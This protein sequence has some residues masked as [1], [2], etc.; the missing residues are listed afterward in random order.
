MKLTDYTPEEIKSAM[1]H[2]NVTPLNVLREL[3]KR[4]GKGVSTSMISAI[5][6]QRKS[7]R[8]NRVEK[9]IVEMCAWELEKQ[10]S[11]RKFEDLGKSDPGNDYTSFICATCGEVI[12]VDQDG[13]DDNA[14]RVKMEDG[15]IKCI[16][17]QEEE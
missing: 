2:A 1:I 7:S 5:V 16:E 9:K 13:V 17:C 12:W 6:H 11:L 4:G 8:D 10:K 3:M 14:N 15:R